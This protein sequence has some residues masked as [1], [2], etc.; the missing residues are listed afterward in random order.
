MWTST[1]FGAKT[2]KF[3]KIYGMSARTRR[4]QCGQ[5][6]ENGEINFL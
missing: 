6:A 5:F 2:S 3:I 4:G 1:L